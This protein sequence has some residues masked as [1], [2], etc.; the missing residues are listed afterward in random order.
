[1]NSSVAAAVRLRRW[2]AT[3]VA[4]FRRPKN[5]E[6][7]LGSHASDSASRSRAKEVRP[8]PTR[9]ATIEPVDAPRD[10]NTAPAIVLTETDQQEINRRRDL[11]RGWFN[12]FWSGRDDKPASFVDRLDEAEN[13]INDRLSASGEDWQ[14]DA[15]ARVMLSLPIR[16]ASG[17]DLNGHSRGARLAR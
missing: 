6:V 8:E 4:A 14:L 7:G 11:V 12:D 3:I 2:L 9:I 1:M 16:T 13:Y 10:D 17:R 5:S 15:E